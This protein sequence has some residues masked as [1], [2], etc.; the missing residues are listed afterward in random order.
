MTLIEDFESLK[1]SPLPEVRETIA[2]KICDYYNNAI[3]EEE[4]EAIAC[5]IIRLFAKDVEIRVRKSLA[6]S[7]KTNL[8]LPHDVALKLA[9]DELD[10]A[11]PILEF[12]KVLTEGDL[13]EIIASTKSVGKLI[14]ITKRDD[15]TNNIS[16]A[17]VHKRN[18]EVCQSLFS[19]INAQISDET[20]SIAI[21]EFAKNGNIVNTLM[22]RGGLSI[23]VVEKMISLTT[24]E[25]KTKIETQ[26]AYN[27]KQVQAVTVETRE[28]ATLDLLKDDPIVDNSNK[29]VEEEES[30]SS[31][32]LKSEQLAKHL[33]NSKRLTSSIMLRSICEGNLDFF[34]ASLSV[35]SGIPLVNV[36]AL[37]RS[38][39]KNAL[40]SLFKRADF[41]V[42]I[43]DSI[44]VILDFIKKEKFSGQHFD[45]RMKQKLV[46]YIKT[47]KY[48]NTVSLMPYVLALISSELSLSNITD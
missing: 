21:E 19:N 40:Y 13:L 10:V 3:F 17:L 25:L 24:D 45:K 11:V 30:I 29:K 47:N 44:Y 20:L 2:K 41:P 38:G 15:I 8:N 48:E 23:G 46:E 14:A 18:E 36:R 16:S 22:N 28:R 39:E 31:S 27:E 4:E 9:N 26:L 7:L 37:V 1:K 33:Y 35:C 6:E 34:E 5:E 42:S 43:T 32:S 12:S